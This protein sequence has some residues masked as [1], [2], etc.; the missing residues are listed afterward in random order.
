MNRLTS[1][2]TILSLVLVVSICS[3]CLKRSKANQETPTVAEVIET[4]QVVPTNEST[5]KF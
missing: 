2:F 3:G 5:S 1:V 4:A